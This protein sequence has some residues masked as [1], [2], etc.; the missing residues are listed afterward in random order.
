MADTYK[1]TKKSTMPDG[2][3]IQIE[4]WIP[5]Y[6]GLAKPY[7]L[8]TYPVSKFSLRGAFSPKEGR[9]FRCAFDFS[10]MSEAE[11]AFDSLANGSAKL[12]DFKDKISDARHLPC[13]GR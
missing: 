3:K 2:T 7:V 12:I 1:I 6:P 8:A 9:V 4:D 5:V 13:I 10:S 11:K